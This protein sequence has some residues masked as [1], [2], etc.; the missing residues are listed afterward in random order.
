MG[1]SSIPSTVRR[2]TSSS[3]GDD[4]PFAASRVHE[5]PWQQRDFVPLPATAISNSE[6][7]RDGVR[8]CRG[9]AVELR[10]PRFGPG[11]GAEAMQTNVQTRAAAPGAASDR[12]AV[13]V[14]RNGFTPAQ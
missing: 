1:A 13:S 12:L 3:T 8:L 14:A 6:Q 11:D 7:T 5:T 4:G 10:C 2:H 9:T